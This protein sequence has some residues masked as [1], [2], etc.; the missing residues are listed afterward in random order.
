MSQADATIIV[1]TAKGGQHELRPGGAD[2]SL[3]LS[4]LLR[5]RHLPLNA[6]CGGRGLCDGCMVELCAGQLVHMP[7]GR[8]ITAGAAPRL[9]RGCEHRVPGGGFVELRVPQRSLLAYAPQVVTDYRLNVARSHDPLVQKVRLELRSVEDL[10]SSLVHL[11]PDVPVRLDA[12][13]IAQLGSGSLGRRVWATIERRTDHWRVTELADTDGSPLLGAAIDIGTTTVVLMLVDLRTGQ[14]L[15]RTAMFNQQMHMGD[16]VLTRI[17]LCANDPSMVVQL[18]S[19]VT[20][21]TIRPLLSQALSAAGAAAHDVRC[22]AISGNTTMLHLLAGVDPT[23]LGMAPF[24]AAFLDHRIIPASEILGEQA[25][26]ANCHLLPGAAAY[27]GSDLTAGVLASGLL[28]DEGPSLLVDVGTNGEIILKRGDRL[29]GCATAAGPAFEGAGLTAGMRAG[30]GA[31]AHV[32]IDRDPFAVRTETIGG[33]G[34]AK[35]IGLCGS[36]YVDFLAQAR[37]SG[38]LTE[39]GRFEADLPSAAVERL[40]PVP[41]GNDRAFRVAWGPGRHPIG[42]SQGDVAKL[43]QAKAAIAAGIVIL[44]RRE[45]LSPAD[46]RRVH[47]AG[48]FGT[49]MKS[50][51]AI[52]SGLL[53]GFR[54]DQIEAVGNTALA[55]AF[56]ALTDSSALAEITRLSRRLKVIELNLDPEFE[57]TYIDHLVL[58]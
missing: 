34:E 45:G 53:P 4:D 16:D 12:R 19:A 3:P 33:N 49:H 56:L 14:P 52:A 54:P 32:C 28:Y 36:A 23:S 1:G 51:H 18:Q 35:S 10:T 27:V 31:V 48:G 43:L 24:T 7:S 58:P 50:E 29:I 11:H 42:I 38:L 37:A 57:S 6:R 44:L 55:G 40:T 8:I 46:V 5:R 39:T 15:T 13:V 26:P 9:V 20:E 30:E 47:L 25:T 21:K 17:T 2:L 41:C 22:L